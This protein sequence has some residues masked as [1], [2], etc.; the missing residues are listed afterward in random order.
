VKFIPSQLAYLLDTRATRSNLS[1]FARYLL[2]LAAQVVIYAVLFHVIMLYEGQTHSWVTGF[3]WTLVVMST[4]GFGDI[5]FTSDLGRV[6]SIVVLMSGVIFLLVMLPFLFIRLFY[7]PWLE[8]RMRFRAP[9]GAPEGTTGHVVITE[10]EAVTTSLVDRLRA[11]GIPF[12]IV[13]ADPAQAARLTDEGLPIVSGELD[14]RLTYDRLLIQSARLVLAT[15][16]DKTNTNIT[17]TAREVSPDVPIAAF[18]ENDESVEILTLAGATTILPLKRQLGEYLGNRV[19]SGGHDPHV[20]GDVR[21]LQIAELSARDTPFAGQT[22]RDT[23]LRERT[24]V[25]VLGF[26]ERGRLQPAFPDVVIAPTRVLIVAG[27]PEQIAALDALLPHQVPDPA[28]THVIVIGAGV[29]GLAAA[30]SIKARG[31]TVNAIDKIQT[32]AQELDQVVDDVFVGNAADRQLLERAG[33]G[34]A[35][36]IVLTTN[37]DATNIYLALYCRRLKQDLRI[38]SRITHERNVEAIHRAGADFV[39]SYTSLGVDGVMSLLHGHETVLLGEG[40][41]L[42]SIAVPPRLAGR[43]LKDSGIGQR[44]GMSVVALQH[45]GRLVTQ[46]TGD[47]TLPA[48]AELL[49]LGSL[50]QRR[51]FTEAFEHPG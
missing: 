44:T 13:E 4:L 27:L 22:L 43:R 3:Y 17:L 47:T 32:A 19:Y 12:F 25:N 7:A 51:T 30:R 21:G 20:I 14:N 28:G 34:R 29:V 1:A 5:T 10:Y 16:E 41:E 26:W 24:G 15:G 23:R 9:R 42:F 11:E 8:A 35:A 49:M 36:S 38:V 6:F 40:V 31:L 45:D 37:D 18:A 2:F 33:L 39:L 50:E 46:T 48:G